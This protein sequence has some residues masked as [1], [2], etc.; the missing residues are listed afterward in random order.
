MSPQPGIPQTVP[1]LLLPLG[2][3]LI[4]EGLLAF[5]SGYCHWPIS[6]AK[7][8]DLVAMSAVANQPPGLWT[9][10]FSRKYGENG[11]LVSRSL[12]RRSR[13]SELDN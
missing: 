4:V 9:R 7:K 5:P 12:A 6:R 11:H 13:N 2:L 10:R 3:S 1:L 8:G